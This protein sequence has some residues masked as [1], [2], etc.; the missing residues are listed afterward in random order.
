MQIFNDLITKEEIAQ[1]RQYWADYQYK[2]KINWV[3]DDGKIVDHRLEIANN[4]YETP[5]SPIINRIIATHF[6]TTKILSKWSALQRQTNPHHP[7][8]DDYGKD[9][10]EANTDLRMYTYIIALDTI[11]E[12]KTIVW[13]EGAISNHIMNQIFPTFK[14][15]RSYLSQQEDLDHVIAWDCEG[16]KISMAD[17]FTL[18]GIFSYQA[19]AGCLFNGKKLHTTSYWLKY[20]Q[21][22]YRDL[23]QIHVLT[24][25]HLDDWQYTKV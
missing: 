22:Q 25:Q 2:K 3:M 14:T 1:M 6:D 17:L 5:L 19:G 11:P 4:H 9:E 20:P 16:E 15:R 21:H 23:L 10:C 24:S 7:H 8:I 18:D 12:F 13:T